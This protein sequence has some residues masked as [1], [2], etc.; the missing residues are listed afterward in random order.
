MIDRRQLVATGD[1]AR[2]RLLAEMNGQDHWTGRLSSSALSTATAAAALSLVDHHAHAGMVA[3]GLQWLADNVNADGGWGDTTI[4]PSNEAATLLARS[5]LAICGGEGR[6]G[7]VVRRADRWIAAR[8]GGGGPDGIARRLGELYGED[9]SFAAPILAMC[10]TAGLLGPGLAGWRRVP[11]LPFEVAVLPHRLLKWLGLPVVSYALPALIAIG[12][13]R[14]ERAATARP[15]LR[16]IRTAVGRAAVA[17]LVKLQPPSGGFLEAVPLTSFVAMSLAA[18]GGRPGSV[19]DKAAGFLAATARDDGS[20][21]IDTNLA[22]WVTSLAIRALSVGTDIAAVVPQVQLA[23]MR[24]WLVAQQFRG[25]DPYTAAAPGGWGWTARPGGVPDA[26]D[27][28]GALL[29]LRALDRALAGGRPDA[30]GGDRAAAVTAASDG[31]AWLAGIQNRDGGI[32]TFCRGW[33]KLEFD[34]SSP[35]LT[36]H[37]LLAWRGWSDRLDGRLA[38]KIRRAEAGAMKYLADSQRGDGTWSALW[39]ASAADHQDSAVYGTARVLPALAARPQGTQMAGAGIDWLLANQAHDGGWGG[40]GRTE[41]SIEETAVAVDALGC[42]LARAKGLANRQDGIR[43]AL[44]RAAR[45]LVDRTEAG[46]RFDPAPVG[47]YFARLRY[48]ER[49]YPLIF[50][51]AAMNRILSSPSPSSL[52]QAVIG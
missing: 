14:H 8:C 45:W 5:A 21:P 44:A 30:G 23:A 28:A 18:A 12:S 40:D 10:A 19:I 47:L 7:D 20:W 22:T 41:P 26:D 3:A 46:R 33:G 42:W 32:P 34:R 4:S 51:L 38:A 27:T 15:V 35:E 39:F 25:V 37:C 6:F 17:R 9:L 43:N 48:Y 2:R 24:R 31:A 13:L 29:A 49:L 50:T 16:A 52:E 36:A 1:R 11:Q